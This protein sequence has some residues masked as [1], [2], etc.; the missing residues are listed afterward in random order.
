MYFSLLHTKVLIG[1]IWTL[2]EALVRVCEVEHHLATGHIYEYDIES[3][4][5]A[6]NLGVTCKYTHLHTL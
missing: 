1:S 6:Y 2:M 5:N 3:N 4:Y